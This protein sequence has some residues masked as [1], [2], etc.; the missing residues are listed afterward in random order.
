MEG[1]FEHDLGNKSFSN[2]LESDDEID[3]LQQRFE[4]WMEVVDRGGPIP[5][6]NSDYNFDEMYMLYRKAID[7]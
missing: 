6:D 5:N 7:P 4:W 3:T 1:Q 2:H